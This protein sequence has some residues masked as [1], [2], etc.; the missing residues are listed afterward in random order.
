MIKQV[1]ERLLRWEAEESL[2]AENKTIP[3][4]GIMSSR[5][6]LSE[7]LPGCRIW[8]IEAR[9]GRRDFSKWF[10]TLPPYVKVDK[11]LRTDRGVFKKDNFQSME[12]LDRYLGIHE[13]RVPQYTI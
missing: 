8:N 1:S 7:I 6:K 2:R 4:D 12:A 3:G 9:G 5:K 11:D 10:Q 13:C